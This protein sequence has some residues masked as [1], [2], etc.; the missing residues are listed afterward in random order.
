[1][2]FKMVFLVILRVL[3]NT[4]QTLFNGLWQ[5]PLIVNR[6]SNPLM[7]IGAERSRFQFPKVLG[8][9]QW[10]DPLMIRVG[11]Q[12]GGRYGSQAGTSVEVPLE[13]P[14]RSSFRSL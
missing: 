14:L 6:S 2:W 13:E 8:V 12:Q 10:C 4:F 3:L 11:S 7:Q 1:M 9:N 5:T